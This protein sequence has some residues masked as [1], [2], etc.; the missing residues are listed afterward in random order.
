MLSPLRTYADG[1]E[2]S[3]M[4]TAVKGLSTQ[5][6]QL[7]CAVTSLLG[8]GRDGLRKPTYIILCLWL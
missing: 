5:Q 8:A 3:A 6:Q 7:L 4:M 1:A 2:A